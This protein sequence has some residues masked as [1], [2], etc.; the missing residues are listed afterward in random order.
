LAVVVLAM[1]G[2]T[3]G[4][5]MARTP[6]SQLSLQL[7]VVVAVMETLE[8]PLDLLVVQAVEVQPRR[9]VFIAL[10]QVQ[11][12]RVLLVEQ[13]QQ[14]MLRI[15]TAVLVVALAVWVATAEVLVALG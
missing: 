7:V 8:I 10:V 4:V 9:S 15:V 12:D 14:T 3:Q 5:Q 1:E 11:Q 6:Y 13:A 2:A